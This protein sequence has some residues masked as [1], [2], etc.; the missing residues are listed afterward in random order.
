M[1]LSNSQTQA[2]TVLTM[3]DTI[4]SWILGGHTVFADKKYQKTFS[5]GDNTVKFL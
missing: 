4:I 2:A 5:G 1:A 3:L